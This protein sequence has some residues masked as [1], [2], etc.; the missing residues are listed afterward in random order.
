MTLKTPLWQE[1]SSYSATMD[2][3][4]LDAFFSAPGILAS[5]DLLVA[6]RAA[7]ANMSVDVAAGR[8]VVTGTDQTGQGKYLCKSDSVTNVTIAAAPGAGQSRIDLIVAAVRD[9]DQNGGAN[10][11]WVIEAVTGTVAATGSQVAPAAPASSI[12]LAQIAIGPSVSTIVTANITDERPS[13]TTISEITSAGGQIVTPYTI[14]AGVTTFLTTSTLPVGTWLIIVTALVN[15]P[16]AV[17]IDI[18]V[19]IGTVTGSFSGAQLSS[20]KSSGP[21]TFTAVVTVT[22]AGMLTLRVIASAI[23][24]TPQLLSTSLVQNQSP[25]TGYAAIKIR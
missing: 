1:D 17:N 20:T 25:V 3:E 4:I 19:E 23:T 7:G 15:N 6:Q 18:E 2:R 11:D 10:N 24:G 9:A 16:S 14:T 8:C 21:V 22:T 13:A 12:V 5:G